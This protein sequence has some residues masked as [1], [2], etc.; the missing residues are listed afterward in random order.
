MRQEHA[1]ICVTPQYTLV[2]VTCKE[3][4]QRMSAEFWNLF[5]I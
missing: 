1:V 5:C 2:R 4:R 3:E